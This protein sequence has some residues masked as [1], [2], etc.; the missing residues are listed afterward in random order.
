MVSAGSGFFAPLVQK[1]AA[2]AALASLGD[3]RGIPLLRAAL[4]AFRGD[5]RS[6]AVEQVGRLRL[7]ALLPELLELARRPRGVDPAVLVEA[8]R[9]F[10]DDH[11]PARGALARLEHAPRSMDAEP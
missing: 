4:R 11:V 6:F 1:A 7:D 9:A 2:G 3:A 10:A 8:L 5:G